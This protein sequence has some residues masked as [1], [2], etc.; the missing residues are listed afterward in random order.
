V[1]SLHVAK[2][3]TPHE[4]LIDELRDSTIPK[5]EREHAAAL[6]IEKNLLRL[7]AVA[8]VCILFGVLIE[9]NEE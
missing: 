9:E 3:A 1:P 2:Q 6:E 4:R 8:S 7:L 5:T